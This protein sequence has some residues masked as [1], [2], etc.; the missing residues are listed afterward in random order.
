MCCVC[1]VC[2]LCVCVCVYCV[3]MCVLCVRV[4]VV[5]V[6]YCYYSCDAYHGWCMLLSRRQSAD[7]TA[8]PL[9]LQDLVEKVV[10]LKKAVEKKRRK[11]AGTTHPYF[12]EKLWCVQCRHS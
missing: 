12:E 2:V 11:Q 6:K 1:V 7:E 5:C 8:S 9:A 10:M 4:C 3:C